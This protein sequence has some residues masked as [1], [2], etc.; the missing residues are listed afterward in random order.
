MS[1][2]TVIERLTAAHTLTQEGADWLKLALDPFHDFNHQI[3]GYPDTD[4][5]QTVVSCYTYGYELSAPAGV[6][7]NWDAHIFSMPIASS[8]A[9]TAVTGSAAWSNYT[10]AGVPVAGTLGPLNIYSGAAGNNLQPL[11]LAAATNAYASLPAALS[12]DISGGITRVLG[13]GFEVTN[14]T[15]TI[16]KQGSVTVYRMPQNTA[17]GLATVNNGAGIIATAQIRRMRLPPTTIAQANLLKGTRTWDA[18][19]GV[20]AV[21]V[22][23]NMSNPLMMINSQMGLV[24]QNANPGVATNA[25]ITPWATVG[26]AA[27]PNVSGVEIAAQQFIPFDTTG[28]YF[29][30][31]S[32]ATILTIRLK[33]YVERA[34][35]FDEAAL[36]VLASPSAGY[37][38]T[39][40][41]LY[42]RCISELPVAVKVGDNATGDWW[43]SALSVLSK[44]AG[45][46]GMALNTVMPGAGGIG[47]ALQ[48]ASAIANAAAARKKQQKKPIR[49]SLPAPQHPPRVT[50]QEVGS[51]VQKG[52]KKKSKS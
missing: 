27:A 4:G 25:Y 6:P 28:A 42:A 8:S 31:L 2:N 47:M 12:Y 5:S 15:A 18:A 11:P 51:R 41:S 10:A 7:G 3:A 29:T 48:A 14:T 50:I 20:Y 30:G 40:L 26:A 1:R 43:R 39:A 9:T 17:E 32:N 37:D 23:H 52:M 46:V 13:V 16:N 38:S 24:Q 49:L 44:V 21:P 22:Q 33:I 34:P 35:T 36:A 19:A 45:P